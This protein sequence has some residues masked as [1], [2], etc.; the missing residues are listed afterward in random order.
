MPQP[1]PLASEDAQRGPHRLLSPPALQL[2]RQLKYALVDLF[3][4]ASRAVFFFLP[5]DEARG[6]ALLAAHA[7]LMLLAVAS[8]FATRGV[9]LRT[10]L[11][12]LSALTLGSQLAFHGC[13]VTKAE[14]R[15]TGTDATI[16][17]DFLRACGLPVTRDTRMTATLTTSAVVV[18]LMVWQFT[19][20]ASSSR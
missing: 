8:F 1:L 9:A 7:T 19:V 14:Q 4:A 18:S 16:A 15:L 5:D 12:L 10:A 3:V 11:L 13:I 6:K 20:E 17:D 2:L